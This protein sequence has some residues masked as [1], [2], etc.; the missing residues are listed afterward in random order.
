MAINPFEV[1]SAVAQF[2]AV[3]GIFF[4]YQQIRLSRK[5]AQ[6]QLINDLEK[7][8]VSYYVIFAKLKPGGDRH[9][10]ASLSRE[11]IGQLA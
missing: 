8:F 10:S 6:G 3:V 4:L 5:A 11:E 9:E 7:E 2:A 1:L